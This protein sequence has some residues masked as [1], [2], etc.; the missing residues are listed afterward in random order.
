MLSLLLLLLLLL[1]VIVVV[2]VVVLVVSTMLIMKSKHHAVETYW[3]YKRSTP[4]ILDLPEW[5][6]PSGF[7]TKM[8]SALHNLPCKRSLFDLITP[9]IFGEEGKLRS[10]LLRSFPI[11]LL[12]PLRRIQIFFS[13]TYCGVFAESR[14]TLL[15]NDTRN[16]SPRQR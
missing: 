14:G 8:L 3:G 4:C 9:I 10:S 12:L 13:V 11:V 16:A 7:P 1:L 15:G 6:F 5:S 2:V